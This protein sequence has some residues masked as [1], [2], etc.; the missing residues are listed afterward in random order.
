METQEKHSN[1]T[2]NSPILSRD[3][4][5]NLLTVIQW[6]LTSAPRCLY[7]ILNT[8]FTFSNTAHKISTFSPK[9]KTILW[10]ALLHLSDAHIHNRKLITFKMSMRPCSLNISWTELAALI[11]EA[12]HDN[13]I[14]EILY[15]SS[16]CHDWKGVQL[17]CVNKISAGLSG[18]VYPHT[19]AT[20]CDPGCGWYRVV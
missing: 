15:S 6:M 2:Q 4:T 19:E 1:S 16:I 20:P 3:Q 11:K 7:D 18:A 10:L 14:G 5:R 13:I 8:Y 12:L 17:C 9:Y